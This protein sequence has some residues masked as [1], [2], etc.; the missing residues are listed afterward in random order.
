[1]RHVFTDDV[2]IDT[3]GSG[4]DVVYGADAFLAFLQETLADTVTVHQGHMPEIDLT[5]ETTANGRLGAER[6]SS[7]GPTAC[8]STATATITRPT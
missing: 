2:V 8:A 3:T 7:S 6:R 4:G 5:S 1:M